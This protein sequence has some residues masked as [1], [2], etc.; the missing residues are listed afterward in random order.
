MRQNYL[1][2]NSENGFS[3]DKKILGWSV[4]QKR[5]DRIDCAIKTIGLWHNLFNVGRD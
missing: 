1:W 2:N 4:M 3:A 5:N